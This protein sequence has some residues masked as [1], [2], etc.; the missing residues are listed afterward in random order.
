[1][2]DC[3]STEDM[4]DQIILEQLLN[5]LPANVR[6]WVQEWKPKSSKEA[7]QLGDDDMQVQ[8]KVHVSTQ[9]NL[10]QWWHE[11]SVQ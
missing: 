8:A 10:W 5:A 4:Q 7:S 9:C 1:M 6:V 11:L 3:T 2:K